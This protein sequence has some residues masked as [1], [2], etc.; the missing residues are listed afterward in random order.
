ML[1]FLVRILKFTVKAAIVIAGI[2]VVISYARL[3]EFGDMRKTLLDKVM[4]SYA[5]RIAIDGDIELQM[6]FPPSVAIDGVRISNSKWGTRPDM[7]TAQR[8]VAE[9]DLL[10]LLQ[11]DMAVPR[12]RMIGVDIVVEQKRDGTTNWDE[13]NDFDTAAGPANP[14]TPMIFPQIGGASVSVA[15]GTLTILN[16]VLSAPIV[17]SLNGANI[18]TGGIVPCL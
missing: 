13:L 17:L 7:M 1:S 9:I 2:A 16:N 12:L 18:L 14:A 6:T 10:P 4:N 3:S 5:G 11:G 8:V 15:G